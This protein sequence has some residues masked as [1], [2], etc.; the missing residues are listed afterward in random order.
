MVSI[1][2]EGLAALQVKVA[3]EGFSEHLIWGYQGVGRT[4]NGGRRR[5][6]NLGPSYR[7]AAW[8]IK[9]RA[10]ESKDNTATK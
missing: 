3:V 9:G 7:L 6:G 4:W 5:G 1:D 8:W 10:E 2:V